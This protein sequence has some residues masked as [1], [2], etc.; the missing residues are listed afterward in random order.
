VI[1]Y[2]FGNAA[3]PDVSSGPVMLAHV[4]NDVG[5]WGAGFTKAVERRWPGSGARWKRAVEILDNPLGQILFD[6]T[7]ADADHIILV[8][9]IAQHGVGTSQIRV[10]YPALHKC[11]K[12]LAEVA[13]EGIGGP[14][15]PVHMPRI[16]CGLAGGRWEVVEPIIRETLV[17]AGV[18]VVVYDLPQAQMTSLACGMPQLVDSP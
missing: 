12:M 7:P 16:G 13:K 6:S 18:E 4:C 5:K 11:L 17:R 1:R 2:V 8:N 14:M 15:I 9:M 10:S 3:Y